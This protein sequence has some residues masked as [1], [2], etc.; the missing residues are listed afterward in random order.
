VD[1]HAD[2][3]THA[4]QAYAAQDWATTASHFDAVSADRLTADDLAAYADAVWWLGHIED[5]LRLG[6]AACGA[7]QADSRPAEA[8]LAALQLGLFHLARGDE[9]QSI[10][11]I[12][13]AGRLAEGIPEGP[14][15]GYLEWFTDVELGLLT[16]HPAAAVAAARRVRD[17]GRRFDEPDLVA[18]GLH[19]EGRALI[20]SG[21]VVDGLALVDEAMV[22]VL[23]GRL[24]PLWSGNLY[25]HTIA[26][27][28]EV[29]DVRRM[30]RWT[31]LAERW[32]TTLPAAVVFGGLCG[33]HRAQ[34]L[35]LR[36]EWDEAEQ[37]AARLVEDL[38]TSRL[39]YAAEAWYVVAEA[40]RLR[41]DPRAAVAYDE[42]HARGRD[43]QPGRALL[44]LQEGDAAGAATSI[45]WAVAAAGT[46][47]LR[48]APLCAAGVDIAVAAGRLEDAATA[49]SEVEATAATYATSGLLAEGRAE[50]ALPV[51]RDACRRWQELGAAYDAAGTCVRLAES[52][53]AL[54]DEASAA[55]EVARAEAIYERLGAHRP[56]RELPDGLTLREC[57]VLALVA[58]GR[59]NRQIGEA[60]YISNRTV[61]RHLTNIF[62]K[63]GVTSRTQAA[64][65]AIDRRLTG[66][67]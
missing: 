53:R 64:R 17:L 50:E 2:N 3:L 44:R 54:G 18:L 25:C 38:D 37:L 28:H 16:G 61:A 46:D 42:A 51:L 26:A 7:F 34:L 56:A 29:G 22:T 12:G 19:G 45:R 41:G 63:I 48:R 33:V 49:A 55:A 30:T 10:G 60:L 5:N 40:R 52:Y 59:S 24:T 6:A 9:P 67:R 15:H 1:E 4:R 35:L 36:G 23:D 32:L 31:D 20:K 58:D 65:Y 21:H 11:W 27:C 8:A 62:T 14:V 43:P 57:E 39:D 47:P 66:T 13:R